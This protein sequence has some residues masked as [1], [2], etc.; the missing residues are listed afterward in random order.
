MLASPKIIAI[1]P[2]F[3]AVINEAIL[4]YGLRGRI[5]SKMAI[6]IYTRLDQNTRPAYGLFVRG[7]LPVPEAV[8][9]EQRSEVWPWI[10]RL[11]GESPGRSSQQPGG[12]FP[13]SFNYTAQSARSQVR[14]LNH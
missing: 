1:H 5:S 10:P 9:H 14:P 7:L 11:E 12:Q 2:I 3:D 4:D 8:E 6:R 13:F